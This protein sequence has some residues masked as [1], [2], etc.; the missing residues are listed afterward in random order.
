[1]IAAHGVALRTVALPLLAIGLLSP[2]GC[3][4]SPA[5]HYTSI[6]MSTA[7]VIEGNVQDLAPVPPQAVIDM[8]QVPGCASG[9]QGAMRSEEYVVN[10]GKVANVFVYVESGLGS[11]VYAPPAT[12]VVLDQKGCR[13]IPH[14]IGVM[15]GQPVEFRTD[16]STM[17]NINIQP[18]VPGNGFF[19]SDQAAH[20]APVR[21]TFSQ[22]ETMIPVRCNY[23]PWMEAFV[24]VAANPFYAV[25]DSQGH[26]VIRGLPPGAYTLVAQQEKLGA[27]RE[28]VTVS[29]GQTSKKD[30]AFGVSTH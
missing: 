22:P 26:F 25:T 24:N 28:S 15:A 5:V 23:H 6:D 18:T 9:G 29:S 7:G 12:P 2:A 10:D 20:G 30:F 13:Y 14:V 21:H 27:I 4:K 1:L 19:N 11:K 17:H 8:S 3:K 16:D